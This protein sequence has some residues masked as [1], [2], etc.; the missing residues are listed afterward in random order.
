MHPSVN[1]LTAK[2]IPMKLVRKGLRKWNI[3]WV[4]LNEGK[5]YPKGVHKVAKKPKFDRKEKDIW[6]N[7][8]DKK[9]TTRDPGTTGAEALPD[10]EISGENQEGNQ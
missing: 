1:Y 4:R 5:L 7:G 2:N 8:R 10:E 3:F 6:N 9:P